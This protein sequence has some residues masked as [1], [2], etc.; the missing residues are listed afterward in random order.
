MNHGLK[1]T[2]FYYFEIKNESS[3]FD[4][5]NCQTIIDYYNSQYL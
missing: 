2:N 5:Y 1:L 4:Y 3:V